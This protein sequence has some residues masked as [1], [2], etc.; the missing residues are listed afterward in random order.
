MNAMNVKW[1]WWTFVI[2]F[3]IITKS[4]FFF[5]LNVIHESIS[6]NLWNDHV[7][8]NIIFIW[9]PK[10]CG[11]VFDACGY[12]TST[13]IISIWEMIIVHNFLTTYVTT[14]LPCSHYIF[15]LYFYCFNLCINTSFS[16]WING[17]SISCH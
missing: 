6:Q 1:V 13:N 17:C 14:F 15:T 10:L 3:Y 16:L 2:K 7:A 4:L 5:F 11:L 8:M 12:A 9:Y